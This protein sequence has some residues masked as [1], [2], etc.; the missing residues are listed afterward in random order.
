MAIVYYNQ[1]WLDIVTYLTKDLGMTLFIKGT[2]H[3]TYRLKIKEHVVLVTIKVDECYEGPE[4]TTQLSTKDDD[5]KENIWWHE[6][7]YNSGYTLESLVDFNGVEF[8]RVIIKNSI[9]FYDVW[10]YHADF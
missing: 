7:P 9:E 8:V 3:E 1:P 6:F 2:S 4:F 10:R 5:I